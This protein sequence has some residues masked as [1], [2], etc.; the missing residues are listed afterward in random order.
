MVG[1]FGRVGAELS[2]YEFA[3][4]LFTAGILHPQYFSNPVSI[5]WLRASFTEAIECP[6]AEEISMPH[7]APCTFWM[8][9]LWGCLLKSL[10]FEDEA[11][12]VLELVFEEMEQ[13]AVCNPETSSVRQLQ[14]VVAENLTKEYVFQHDWV[15]AW[16]WA[17]RIQNLA[18]STFV[19][20][21][22][23]CYETLTVFSQ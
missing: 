7:R 10:G 6:K 14:A 23:K 9:V 11:L 22:Q 8:T 3:L 16:S 5:A 13:Y 15:N 20:L 12:L 1:K 18:N 19:Q 17:A 2:T 4:S 21:P